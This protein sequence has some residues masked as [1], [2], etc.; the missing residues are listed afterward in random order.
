MP[1]TRGFFAL[2]SAAAV[3]CAQDAPKK[4]L[5]ARELFYAATKPATPKTDVPKAAPPVAPRSTR[6][7]A[8]PVEIAV[9]APQM[10][11]PRSDPKP[12]PDGRG[13]ITHTAAQTAPMPA[14]GEPPLGLR[15]NVLSFHPDGSTT[16]VLPDTVFHSG[17]R[18]QLSIETNGRGFLYI[19][20]QGASGEWHPMFPAPEI[21]NGDNRVEPMRPYIMPPYNTEAAKPRTYTFDSIAGQEKLFVVFSRQPVPEFDELIYKIKGGKAA[22]ESAKPEDRARTD[23]TLIMAAN[24]GDPIISRMRDAYARDLIIETVTTTASAAPGEKKDTAIYVVNPTGSTDSHVVADI[25]LVH[26]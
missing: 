7:P 4:Q 1:A 24:I 8:K 2:L 22:G 25:Q 6:T 9:A 15:I 3:L 23:K 10:Q 17:D 14:N 19:A 11:P 16:E 20:N 12:T 13:K 26:Q 18:I 21:A 5:T